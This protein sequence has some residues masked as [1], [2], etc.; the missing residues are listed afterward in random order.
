MTSAKYMYKYN[1]NKYILFYKYNI[2][3]IIKI[4]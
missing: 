1:T 4:Q 3:I 2:K